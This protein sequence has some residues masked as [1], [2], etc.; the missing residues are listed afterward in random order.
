MEIDIQLIPVP[1]NPV[2]LSERMVIVM[3]VLRATSVIVQAFSE[4][5]TEIIPVK[6]VEE[7]F[8]KAK[9]FPEG[10]TLL[11]GERNSRKIQGFDLGNSPKEYCSERIRG[12]RII[13]TT[14]NG[15][16]AFYLVSSGKEV[17]VGSFFNLRAIARYCLSRDEDLLIFASGDE[18]RFSLED[19]VCGGM[20]I[21]KIAEEG[22]SVR[23]TDAAFASRILYERFKRNPLEAFYASHHG[24]DLVKK[25]FEEDL[26][27]CARSDISEV[28]PIFR[29]GAIRLHRE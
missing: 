12:K 21:E 16:R 29:Q 28:I 15:T 20:L 10:T 24:R 11:G 8:E 22:G 9:A 1:L 4:G 26:L 17:L 6:T 25:G 19:V 2:T 13:L 5:A 14:T 27:F 7:A 3:D 23:L 18:G